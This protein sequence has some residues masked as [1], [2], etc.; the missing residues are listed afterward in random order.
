MV[1]DMNTASANMRLTPTQLS[2]MIREQQEELY[3]KE[4]EKYIKEQAEADREREAYYST[5]QDTISDQITTANNR[6]AFLQNVKEAFVTE[7][8]MKLYKDSVAA[9]MTK[10]DKVIARNLVTRFVKEHGAG[11]LITSF[12]T[13]N[14]VL[15]EMSRI[16]QKYYNRVV[17]ETMDF[18][19]DGIIG[20]GLLPPEQDD[21]RPSGTK[22]WEV[23]EWK[24]DKTIADDFYSE[25]IDIDTEDAS[26][27]IKDRVADAVQ[28]FIDSNSIA[29]M[30]Y[31]E[32]INQAQEKI[33]AA[34]NE[35]LI[36]EYSAMAKA[37]IN[38][39][40]RTRPKSIFNLMVESLTRK[41]II[42]DN[43]K[44]RYVHEGTVDMDSVVDDTML[45]Y[46]MLEMV[47]TTRMVN[48]DGDFLM[49]YLESLK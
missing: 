44:A 46:T 22:P 41:S 13:K 27:M 48:V 1:Y 37:K 2:R 3:A 45:I 35:A 47:N 30:E 8:I 17:K 7:C 26:K 9:P 5:I 15:S 12:A 34:K 33:A 14:L 40:K 20:A 11:N 25:L 6:A 29:K 36:E 18:S 24:L 4:Q 32:I 10:N 16:S 49:D 19:T 38:D 21:T 43:Y 31:E 28:G 42:D 23:K 39:M